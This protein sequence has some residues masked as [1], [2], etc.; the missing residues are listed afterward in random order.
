MT[1]SPLRRTLAIVVVLA[2]VM[3]LPASAA[4]VL[5]GRNGRIVFV[6]GRAGPDADDSQA[7]LYFWRQPADIFSPAVGPALDTAV[8]QHRHP[9]ISP[10]RTKIAYA[11]GTANS[12]PATQNFDI[13]IKDLETGDVQPLTVTGDSLSEDRPAW[14]PDGTRIAYEH[15]PA[16]ASTDRIIRVETVATGATL[17]LTALG[18]PLETKPA[19]S[20]DSQ[21]LYYAEGDVNVA[22]N[23]SNNDVKILREPANNTG[24]GT[25]LIHISGAHAFQPS[26]S[27][28]GTRICFTGSATAGLNAMASI[29]VAEISNPAGASP[30]ASSGSGDYN[31]TWSPNGF[32]VAYVSGVFTSGALVAEDSDNSDLVPQTLTDD[33]ANFDG[34]PDW[35]P[36]AAPTCQDGTVTTPVNTAVSI[37]LPCTDNGPAYEQT[38]VKRSIDDQPTNGSVNLAQPERHRRHVHTEPRLR[39][40]RHLHLPPLRRLRVRPDLEHDHRDGP[41]ADHRAAAD[42]LRAPG[43][44]LRHE[45]HRRPDRH[46]PEPM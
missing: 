4:G 7:R 42:V 45:R 11:R 39:R 9:T 29:F 38:P 19:W 43:D 35:A 16:D 17:D 1:S 20:P 37:P 24:T 41:A 23:G 8:G 21:T 12:D 44:D 30:L 34:N 10:D 28:D 32:R 14:S 3:A 26:I 15:Q 13:Y 33:P 2:S 18:G 6:S 5:S 36:D 40:H 25:E 22:P 27:P 31:C 46:C